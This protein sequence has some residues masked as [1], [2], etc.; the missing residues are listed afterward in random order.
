MNEIT[1][2]LILTFILFF[3]N[4]NVASRVLQKSIARDIEVLS[5]IG[6]LTIS[7]ETGD[8]FNVRQ[9]GKLA[10]LL[11]YQ[12]DRKKGWYK[13]KKRKAKK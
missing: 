5:L 3:I 9:L 11:G 10:K 8:K 13:I 2:L 6:K 7:L 4:L 12:Y 1:A